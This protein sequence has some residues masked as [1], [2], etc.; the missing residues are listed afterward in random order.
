MKKNS[1]I[2]L[3]LVFILLF[4]F[5]CKKKREEVKKK[6]SDVIAFKVSVE[7]AKIGDI[8]EYI[9]Y[10]GV[11]ESLKKINVLPEI[12]GRIKRMYKNIGDRVKK[13]ELLFELEDTIFKSQYEQAKAGLEAAKISF[14]DAKKNMERMTAVYKKNGVSKAQYEQAVSAFKLAKSNLERAKAAFEMASFQYNS[15]KI[16]APFPG[17]ITGK[18]KEEGDFINPSMGGFSQGAGVYVLEDYSKIYVN[19]DIPN[20]DSTLIK[21][22]EIADIV[23]DKTILK[24]KVYTVNEKSDPMSSSIS[25]KVIADNSEGKILPGNIVKVRIHYKEKKNALIIP[26]KA[27]LENN[28]VFVKKGDIVREVRVKTGLSNPYYTEIISGINDGDYVVT[29]GNFG[30]FDKA[31][32]KEETK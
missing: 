16:K 32:V 9:E 18:L 1:L 25:I 2:I 21:K 15:T 11:V 14:G 7:K 27:I 20:S 22:G 4:T 6:G 28:I 31:K 24:G 19:I 10:A 12:A 3:G 23:L 5:S 30:L 26:T 8:S 17:V 13:G 29:E